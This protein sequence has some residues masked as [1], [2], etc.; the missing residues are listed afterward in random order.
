MKKAI[1]LAA[2]MVALL[3][4][5]CTYQLRDEGITATCAPLNFV[6]NSHGV[7]L[8]QTQHDAIVD[9]VDAV[10]AVDTFGELVGR[11]VN[12]LGGSTITYR[13]HEV[14]DPIL[15][16]LT[17]P[18]DAPNFLGF[19]SPYID[20]EIYNGGWLYFN[21]AIKTA[22]AGMVKRLVLHEI[23]HLAGLGDVFDD[24]TELM[25]PNLTSQ[26]W[27][28][29]DLTGLT[30]T[31]NGGCEGANLVDNLIQVA[32]NEQAGRTAATDTEW[33]TWTET[34]NIELDTQAHITA[35]NENTH[36][37]H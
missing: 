11:E 9:G 15:I 24:T 23:G 7:G 19:A 21:P 12:Y 35:H 27:G 2:V 30:V 37:T 36:Q 1:T 8:G 29:G 17:W 31:H 26:D 22:P 33:L 32:T 34:N 5:S 6:I 3:A 25:N 13:D 10:D 20:N 16:E 14:G 4:T 28:S 18:D